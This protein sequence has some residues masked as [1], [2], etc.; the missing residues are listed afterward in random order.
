M[1]I[2]INVFI[3]SLFNVETPEIILENPVVKCCV[4]I[5]LTS[6]LCVNVHK[7]GILYISGRL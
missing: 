3:S 7:T 2:Q 1:E 6:S 4:A 5:Q